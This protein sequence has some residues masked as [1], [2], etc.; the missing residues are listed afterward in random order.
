MSS[1][2]QPSRS[3][4]SF[5]EPS[6]TPSLQTQVGREVG[7]VDPGVQRPAAP[8]AALLRCRRRQTNPQP[9]APQPTLR[10][11]R[12]HRDLP[13]FSSPSTDCCMA[14]LHSTYTPP[15]A[16]RSVVATR[17]QGDYN[18]RA[19]PWLRAM[20]CGCLWALTLFGGC[21]YRLCNACGLCYARNLAKPAGKGTKG[22]HSPAGS[23]DTSSSDARTLLP[24]EPPGPAGQ[25][26]RRHTTAG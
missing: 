26:T 20:W 12:H 4:A 8:E 16:L 9:Y 6:L 15:A 19:Q 22:K 10:G 7:G 5:G 3:N 17:T 2:S 13:G 11:V 24:S 14:P 21:G 25:K 23:G 18:V 1:P